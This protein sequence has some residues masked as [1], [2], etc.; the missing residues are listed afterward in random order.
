VLEPY[1]N[2]APAAATTL[3]VKIVGV[4]VELAYTWYVNALVVFG[5][6]QKSK[7]H[8]SGVLFP[9]SAK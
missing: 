5:V 2:A 3:F 6:S 9:S 7:L 4:A 1:S 8:V